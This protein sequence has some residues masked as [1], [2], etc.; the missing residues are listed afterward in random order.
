MMYL[1]RVSYNRSTKIRETD[2]LADGQVW[3]MKEECLAVK[4]VGRYLVE[5]TLTKNNDKHQ[6][7]KQMRGFKQ[8]LSIVDVQKF[9]RDRKALLV[10]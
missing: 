7:Q 4:H 9:L 1:P 6:A 10:K 3:K 2:P 8:L 5:C